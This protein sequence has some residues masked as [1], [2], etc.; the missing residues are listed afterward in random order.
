LKAEVDAINIF[1]DN[2][3]FSQY[4]KENIDIQNSTNKL[5]ED[6]KRIGKDNS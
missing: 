4:N 2:S 1:E 5:A 6:V 3:I